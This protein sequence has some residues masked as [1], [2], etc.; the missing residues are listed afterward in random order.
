M[1]PELIEAINNNDYDIKSSMF[2][3]YVVEFS[4]PATTFHMDLKNYN[5]ST[6]ATS[7]SDDIFT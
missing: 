7:R 1:I 6:Y 3:E 4:M 5:S 2:S